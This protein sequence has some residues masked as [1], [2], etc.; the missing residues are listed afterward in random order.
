MLTQS[1]WTLF[2]E[3]WPFP[4]HLEIFILGLPAFLTLSLPWSKGAPCLH[5]LAVSPDGC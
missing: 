1:P 2:V 3:D 4:P 5:S